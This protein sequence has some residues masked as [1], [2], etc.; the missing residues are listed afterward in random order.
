MSYFFD[1]IYINGNI[2]RKF[3]FFNRIYNLIT[4]LATKNIIFTWLSWCKTF[5]CLLF[6]NNFRY[7]VLIFVSSILTQK[8]LFTEIKNSLI[9]FFI[10]SID[11]LNCSIINFLYW[12][13]KFFL[14]VYPIYNIYFSNYKNIT[15]LASSNIKFIFLLKTKKILKKNFKMCWKLYFNY[16]QK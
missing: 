1:W 10:D 13:K 3:F 6:W 16:L 11:F 4:L 12:K 9:I 15:S 5:F 8:N 2:I 14:I 7:G